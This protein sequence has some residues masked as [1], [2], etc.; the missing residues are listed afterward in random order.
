MKQIAE[1]TGVASKPGEQLKKK[2]G[3]KQGFYTFLVMGGWILILIAIVGIAFL[4]DLL[5]K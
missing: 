4:I 5:I 1:E 2:K 3:A